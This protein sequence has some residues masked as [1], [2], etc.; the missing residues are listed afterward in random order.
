MAFLYRLFHDWPYFLSFNLGSLWEQDTPGLLILSLRLKS[1]KAWFKGDISNHVGHPPLGA[2]MVVFLL[3]VVL[4]QGIS[5]LFT[6]DDIFTDGPWRSA[7]SSDMQDYA[8]WI[9]GNFF[10]II[11]VAA[12]IHIAAA[13]YYLLVKKTNLIKPMISG[14]KLVSES[15]G[16][17]SSKLILA[18]IVLLI[19]VSSNLY[20]GFNGSRT[21]GR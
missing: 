6:T 21:S 14:R 5:G 20:A 7:L 19:V 9:H 3:I 10:T 2:L 13:F 12:A 1:L 4:A 18:L 16:I 8:D 17:K 11:Q 15:E